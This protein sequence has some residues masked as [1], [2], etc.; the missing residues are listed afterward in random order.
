MPLGRC[1]T[2]EY[3]SSQSFM[4]VW[5]F[6]QKKQKS[7]FSKLKAVLLFTPETSEPNDVTVP[8][9]RVQPIQMLGSGIGNMGAQYLNKLF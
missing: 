3:Y 4:K 6:D 1:I 9:V 5:L 2:K 8:F 7:I